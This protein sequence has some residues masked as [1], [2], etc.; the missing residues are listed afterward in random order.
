MQSLEYISLAR[1]LETAIMDVIS[2][3]KWAIKAT[4]TIMN[5][6]LIFAK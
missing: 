1:F 2:G 5:F 4:A 6:K 3:G